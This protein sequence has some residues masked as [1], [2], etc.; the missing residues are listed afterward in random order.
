MNLTKDAEQKIAQ[1]IHLNKVK[2]QAKHIWE[3]KW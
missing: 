3:I 1:L 2:K